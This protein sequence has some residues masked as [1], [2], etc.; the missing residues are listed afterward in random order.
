MPL[1]STDALKRVRTA[2]WIV[3]L[4]SIAGLIFAPTDRDGFRLILF[5]VFMLDAIVLVMLRSTI[6]SRTLPP[7]PERSLMFVV[8]AALVWGMIDAYFFG[9]GLIS[10]ILFLYGALHFL[11]RAIAVREDSGLFRLRLSKAIIVSIAGLAALGTIVYG[12][13]VARERAET[14]IVAIEQFYARHGRYPESLEEVV[15]VFIAE[16]PKAK[17]VLTAETFR[18]SSRDSSHWLMYV[19]VPPF[20]RKIYTFEDHKWTYLD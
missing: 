4:G 3:L 14:L 1:P 11:P 9:Q 8:I 16:I 13:V 12:N 2:V 20:G 6:R 5:S 10:I 19:E 7:A 15:P 17:Y 18:Y